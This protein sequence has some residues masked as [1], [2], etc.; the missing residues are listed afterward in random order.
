MEKYFDKYR[1]NIIGY[2]QMMQSPYGEKRIIYADWIASGRLYLP[3]EKKMQEQFGPWVANTH[4]ET[5]ETGTLMTKSY[6]WAHQII[7]NHVN[8]ND[9]DVLITNGNGMTG[10]IN[11]F[12][13]ILGMRTYGK[14]KQVVLKEEDRPIVFITH[15]E[16]HSNQTS[17]LETNADVHVLEPNPDLTVNP[18][19]LKLQ[20]KKYKNRKYKIGSFSACSNVTGV[21]TDY[22]LLA[23]IMHQ[24]KG[25]CFV[26]FAAN[27]PYE[28]MNMH[29]NDPD[30]ALDAIFFSPHKFLG[31][32]G[33]SGV[34]LFNKSLYSNSTPDNPGG[35][36]VAWTNPWG[37]YQYLDD[38][39]LRE[40]GGTPGFLQAIRI[41]LAIKLK[42]QIGVE[43]MRNREKQLVKEAFRLLTP[44]PGLKI[45][46]D[47]IQD[48]MGIISF[49][50]EDVH[51]N[52]VV[53]MLN[54]RFGVQVRG[55]CACA[56]TYGH[57]LMGITPEKSKA[58]VEK[59]S[60]GDLSSKP[61]WIRL[62]LHPSMTNEELQIVA[63][64][65]QEISTHHKEWE[66]DYIY[67]PHNNEF[68]HQE[69]TK[70]KIELV[71]KW[72]EFDNNL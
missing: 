58:I 71:K 57:F 67:N 64:G 43:K 62:S 39:E 70:D 13:R 63:K 69:E 25:L 29:P 49:Y 17:W 28:S 53:K 38:I 50:M 3:I 19:E 42:E 31:G 37:G 4:T 2:H 26:D 45:L 24:N 1:R 16:H 72:F 60:H 11:K 12:Q 40:D 44:I 51:Y 46:S 61:G 41:A 56:G 15:M 7:K 66:K 27:A 68:K 59:I 34:L 6:H 35:G 22:H 8:A 10:V 55:G 14:D 18:E 32:P 47:H 23:K 33:S 52:L 54:D 48:R 21:H 20:L 30:E 65:L 5:S 9:N 36:T